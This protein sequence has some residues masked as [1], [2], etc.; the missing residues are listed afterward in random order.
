M[1]RGKI[2]RFR[3]IIIGAN[4]RDFS[5]ETQ[6]H[7]SSLIRD[8][9]STTPIARIGID[10]IDKYGLVYTSAVADVD[11]QLRNVEDIIF[12]HVKSDYITRTLT[13]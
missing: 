7:V 10:M 3:C 8:I 1:Y 4:I 6:S 13:S 9:F 11:G 5:T 2:T 12:G